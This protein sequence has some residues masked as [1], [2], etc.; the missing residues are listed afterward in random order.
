MVLYGTGEDEITFIYD[1]G[2]R[3]YT[4]SKPFEG[5]INNIERRWRETDSAWVREELARYQS[6]QPC[7]ACNGYRL[8][9]QAL[10]VKIA[11]LHIG[12]VTE[13]SIREAAA[14]FEALP[15]IAHAEAERDRRSASSRR[16]AS[17]CSFLNDVG[18][19]YLTLSRALGHAVRRREPAHPAGLADR[20]GPDRRALRAGRAVD[21]AASARQCPAARNAEG[22]CAT[23]AT[24]CS[25]S[26]TTRRRS[27]R[28]TMSSTWARA[29][30]CMAARW[31]P[32]ARPS[33]SWP[34]RT[35]SPGNIS[36]ASSRSP[37]RSSG[38]S[39]P[40]AAASRVIGARANNLKNVTVDIPLGLFTC[41]HRR[42]GRRQ[43]DLPDRDALPGGGA[44][45]ERRA[46]ACPA[47]TTPSRAWSCSTR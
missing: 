45:A 6:E 39:P 16:S 42:V 43:V 26:S 30:A 1:D 13:M 32:R 28:P 15:G 38:A 37:R 33:R 40:R 19:D 9:P 35:A 23:S 14:W 22:A 24:P 12:Q 4:T 27:S 10:A 11:G 31:S 41:G 29:P 21:R 47:S 18:L 46:R 25:W 7:E 34:T 2:V 20:L 3:H 8:K 36:P 44:Q 5:V 17:G